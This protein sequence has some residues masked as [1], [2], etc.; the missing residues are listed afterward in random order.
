MQ[1][2]IKVNKTIK[3]TQFLGFV[4][5]R[6]NPENKYCVKC[7]GTDWSCECKGFAFR[8]NC[9][10]IEDAKRLVELNEKI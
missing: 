10:H 5:S 8:R 9:N 4:Q 7:D 2:E 3:Q 1:W 6:T